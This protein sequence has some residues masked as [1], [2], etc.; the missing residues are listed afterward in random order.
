[1]DGVY[2]KLCAHIHIG[3]E[4]TWDPASNMANYVV[5]STERSAQWKGNA[6]LAIVGVFGPAFLSLSVMTARSGYRLRAQSLR[7]RK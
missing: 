7:H 3:D 6:L 4:M 1:M 5:V 2:A